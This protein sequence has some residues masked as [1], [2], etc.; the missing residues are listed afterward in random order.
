MNAIKL[1]DG[2]CAECLDL[3]QCF[4][5]DGETLLDGAYSLF[6]PLNRDS[7]LDL[8]FKKDFYYFCVYSTKDYEYGVMP[9]PALRAKSNADDDEVIDVWIIEK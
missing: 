4:I 1:L 8:W 2:L 5:F 3:G 9:E 7:V 6:F